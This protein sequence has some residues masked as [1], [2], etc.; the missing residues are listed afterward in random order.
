MENKKEVKKYDPDETKKRVLSAAILKGNKDS[1][2]K[3]LGE[4]ILPACA[5]NNKKERHGALLRFSDK[6][7]ELFRMFENESHV[8]LME[9]FE[10]RYRMP[11]AEMTKTMIQEFGCSSEAEKALAEVIVN[12][13]MRVID[14][15]RRLNN[16]LGSPGTAITKNKTKYLSMLSIQLDRANRQFLNALITLKQLKSP[17]IEMNIKT[18]NTFVAQNQ[19]INT[20]QPMESSKYENNELK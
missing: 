12:A 3:E 11:S 10:E 8:G 5:S 9:T 13:Y 15:S 4:E 19:Q 2:L 16:D 14:N 17:T 18:R 1:L 20:S 7:M 6:S